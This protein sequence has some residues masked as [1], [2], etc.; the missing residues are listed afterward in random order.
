VVVSLITLRNHT[1][2]NKEKTAEPWL[3][4]DFAEDFYGETI[5]LV[6]CAYIR[7]EANFES[8]EAL[9]QRIHMDA[10]VAR[11]ALEEPAYLE[12]RGDPFLR[13]AA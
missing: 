7:P 1:R 10:D 6:V 12:F 3:L 8:V 5:R 4:H 9:V 11:E 2:R 13:P